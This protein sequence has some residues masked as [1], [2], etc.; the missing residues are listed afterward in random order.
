MEY[1]AMHLLKQ[2]EAVHGR[3]EY[4]LDHQ[5]YSVTDG[6]L[7]MIYSAGNKCRN[8]HNTILLMPEDPS[9]VSFGHVTYH[10]KERTESCRNIGICLDARLQQCRQEIYG[11]ED[12][13]IVNLADGM[14]P[15]A[16]IPLDDWISPFYLVS[17]QDSHFRFMDYD[18]EHLL[19]ACF[20]RL[21]LRECLDA[22]TDEPILYGEL[23]VHCGMNDPWDYKPER[24]TVQLVTDC[25][26]FV[27]N[28]S[29]YVICTY[30]EPEIK[31]KGEIFPYYADSKQ[32]DLNFLALFNMH[33]SWNHNLSC[34][35][36]LLYQHERFGL[37]RGEFYS[38]FQEL[39]QCRFQL[40]AQA[41]R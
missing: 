2:P 40:P 18:P 10:A 33:G 29:R 20:W 16:M 27:T 25:P 23:D 30:G 1:E 13:N 7:S 12:A 39:K 22:N 24:F 26:G 17:V 19:P 31:V 34:L 8:N 32:E 37:E 15:A 21:M 41:R 4:E 36:Y 28:K 6:N 14:M 38:S 35:F 5:V 3:S 9:L 11:S